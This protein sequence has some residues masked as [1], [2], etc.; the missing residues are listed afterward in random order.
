[1]PLQQYLNTINNGADPATGKLFTYTQLTQSFGDN[2]ADHRTQSYNFFAQ[3]DLQ[4]A[5][6]LTLSPGLRYELTRE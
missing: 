3:D 2:V 5:R 1:M 6:R 4:L